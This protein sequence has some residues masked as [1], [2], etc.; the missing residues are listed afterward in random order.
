VQVNGVQG[1][2]VDLTGTSP[3]QKNGK[4]IAER[5][6]LVVVPNSKGDGLIALV[7]VSPDNAQSQ[8][9]PTYQKMLQSLQVK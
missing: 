2:A 8:L 5:D 9:Q 1:R 7:F 6:R 3:V 4:P